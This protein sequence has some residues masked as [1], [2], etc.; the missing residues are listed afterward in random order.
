[1]KNVKV[2][3]IVKL[4]TPR[5]E[6]GRPL[7]IA[8]LAGRYTANTLDDVPALWDVFPFTLAKSPDK[9]VAPP[10]GSAPTC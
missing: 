8:G 4:E 6:D 7:L 10:T 3:P 5:F 1:V 2:A 9:Q